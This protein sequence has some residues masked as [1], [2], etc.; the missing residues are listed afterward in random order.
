[1]RLAFVRA[2]IAL[3]AL[4][5]AAPAFPQTVTGT[6]T[7]RAL[8][9]SGGILPGVEVSITSPA[10]IGG[11]RTAFTDEQGVYRFTQLP[12]G[13]YR[14]S[15]K[16]PGFKTLNIEGVRVDTGATM[17][18]NG[19]MQIDSLEESV[20]VVSDTPVIDLQAT[21]VGVNWDEKQMED[22]PYGRGVR[23]LAR[24]VPGLSPTQFD[25]GGNTVGGSTTT[26]ARSYG[27][28][29]EELI[30]FDG[31]V[32]DQFFGDYN[33]YEQVQVSAAAKGAEAQSP[34]LT[35]SFVIKSGSNKLSGMYLGAWQD[36]AFQGNNV[37]PE[38]R[39]RGFDPGDNK[40]T[41]YN[42]VSLDL[43]GPILRD[44]LWFYGAYGYNYS[45]LFIPGFISLK[46]NE[47]VE[48]FTRLDNPTL[49]FTYQMSQNNK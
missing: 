40:F 16:L 33:T 47:Q 43:G 18:I 29:G 46:T 14:V 7:G 20:T 45:G 10:M 1:M 41:R 34:G 49:K 48:Y 30:K 12:A 32:W 39:A 17:T 23:G 37:T 28:S 6:I 5:C 19:T 3:L 24:L 44:K 42:D 31:V 35:L 9:S 11:A 27:R 36:G 8:D 13:E 25:V 38:L 4:A 26:G 2:G 22:L 15:F 21:T